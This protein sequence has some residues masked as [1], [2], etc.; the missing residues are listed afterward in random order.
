MG[1]FVCRPS[2]L[3]FVATWTPKA[4]IDDKKGAR[5]TRILRITLIAPGFENSPCAGTKS[6]VFLLSVEDSMH[7]ERSARSGESA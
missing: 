6:I 7:E 3:T 2:S 1:R 5:I 4:G